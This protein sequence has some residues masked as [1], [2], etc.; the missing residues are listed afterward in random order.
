MSKG[1][2]TRTIVLLITGLIVLAL[3]LVLIYITQRPASDTITLFLRSM[4][5]ISFFLCIFAGM[6]ANASEIV[7]LVT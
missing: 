1:L 6:F 3:I 7:P 5:F 4:H 2:T